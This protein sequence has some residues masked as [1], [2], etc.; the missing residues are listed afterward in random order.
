MVKL[1]HGPDLYL[2]QT[3]RPAAGEESEVGT[4]YRSHTLP[5]R[6]RP[7]GRRVGGRNAP[8]GAAERLY[9]SAKG[10]IDPIPPN[11]AFFKV[12]IHY[13]E[14]E[15]DLRTLGRVGSF[16]MAEYWKAIEPDH[17]QQELFTASGTDVGRF[18]GAGPP[19]VGL[20]SFVAPRPAQ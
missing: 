9:A 3:A 18:L 14:G 20:L 4:N 2:R 17:E 5:R 8:D 11:G 13:A 15:V 10:E 12:K 16:N 7:A 19:A 6:R 1:A